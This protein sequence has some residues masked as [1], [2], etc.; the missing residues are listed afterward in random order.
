MIHP[1]HYNELVS[2]LI[3]RRMADNPEYDFYNMMKDILRYGHEGYINIANESLIKEA[4]KMNLYGPD[5]DSI[6]II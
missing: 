5:V 6:E 1:I 4:L 3:D 2:D